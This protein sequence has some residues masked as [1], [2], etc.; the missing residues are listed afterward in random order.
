LML[1]WNGTVSGGINNVLIGPTTASYPFL[2]SY[3]TCIGNE[4]CSSLLATPGSNVAIGNG[5]LASD[6]NSGSNVAVGSGAGYTAMGANNI[7]IGY[8]SA[9][10]AAADT[11]EIVIGN[12][13]TS[14]KGPNTTTIG[15]S[16]VTATY[17]AGVTLPLVIYSHAGTQLAACASGLQGGT[18][19]VSD[20][21]ALVPGTAYSVTAGAGADTVR[22]QCTLVSGTYAWQTM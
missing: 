1:G 19:V 4:A 2:S 22:V 17:L 3:N 8:N 18:A 21:T 15:N 16:T 10:S 5:A 20:A 13:A 11:N 12:S 9:P 6:N 7:F 14:G